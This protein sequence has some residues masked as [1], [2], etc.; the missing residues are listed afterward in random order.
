MATMGA[1]TGNY[2][3]NNLLPPQATKGGPCVPSLPRAAPGCMLR[4]SRPGRAARGEGRK[5][6]C[7][8][9]QWPPRPPWTAPWWSGGSLSLLNHSSRFS[10]AYSCGRCAPLTAAFI[11]LNPFKRWR[12]LRHRSRKGPTNSKMTFAVNSN[13][14]SCSSTNGV[15][16]VVWQ[17]CG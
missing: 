6:G 10:L 16:P 13:S 15:M 9:R 7:R 1:A 11:K 2:T 12:D 4:P 8:R 14:H 3:V 17:S 5:G